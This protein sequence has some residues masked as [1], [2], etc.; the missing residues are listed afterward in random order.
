[1]WGLYINLWM[2][3]FMGG[4]ANNVPLK[5]ILQADTKPIVD[6]AGNYIL[7]A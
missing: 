4:G 1:M 2:Q 3:M 6:A 7:S 5:A